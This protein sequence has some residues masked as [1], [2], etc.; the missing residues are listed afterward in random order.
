MKKEAQSTGQFATDILNALD[1]SDVN[2]IVI[3]IEGCELVK[4][5]VTFIEPPTLLDE[6]PLMLKKYNLV[7]KT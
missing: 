5:D 4:V 1:I 2:K 3:T 7:E 6:L